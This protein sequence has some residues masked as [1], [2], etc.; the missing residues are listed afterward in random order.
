MTYVDKKHKLKAFAS[1]IEAVKAAQVSRTNKETADSFRTKKNSVKLFRA[2]VSHRDTAVLHRHLLKTGVNRRL[3]PKAF[4][5]LKTNYEL[6]KTKRSNLAKANESRSTRLMTKAFQA[7]L[8][9]VV[10]IVNKRKQ[11]QIADEFLRNKVYE[12]FI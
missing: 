3:L 9:G 1:L 5:A 8:F 4:V 6:A 2:I 11:K 12:K 10:E 7:I